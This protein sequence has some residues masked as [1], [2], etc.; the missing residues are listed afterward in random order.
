VNGCIP[1][2]LHQC[3]TQWV[4]DLVEAVG[5]DDSASI[6]VAEAQGDLSSFDFVSTRDGRFVPVN[7]KPMA[8]NQLINRVS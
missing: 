8:I 7:V 3:I 1:S 6:A 4:G 2:T 5:A